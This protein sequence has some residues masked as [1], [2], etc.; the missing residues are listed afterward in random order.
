MFVLIG[1]SIIEP[2]TANAGVIWSVISTW[3]IGYFVQ[4]GSGELT[5]YISGGD[6]TS[7]AFWGTTS[8]GVYP[9]N[10]PIFYGYLTGSSVSIGPIWGAS[11]GYQFSG[12]IAPDGTMAGNDFQ[13][14]NYDGWWWT[15]W[16]GTNSGQAQPYDAP[17]SCR[18]ALLVFSLVA[19]GSFKL[20]KKTR[21]LWSRGS[22]ISTQPELGCRG[23][24]RRPKYAPVLDRL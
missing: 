9:N 24:R 19:L 3:D 8:V 18:A 14:T 6:F 23:W 2:V 16:W 20:R 10:S 22:A 15:G 4:E 12:T 1:L 7:G 13:R 21:E 17:E 11:N 5:L